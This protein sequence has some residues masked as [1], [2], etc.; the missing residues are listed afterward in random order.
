[1]PSPALTKALPLF[2]LP[3]RVRLFKSHL[4]PALLTY[5][6]RFQLPPKFEPPIGHY[7]GFMANQQC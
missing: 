2:I 6:I 5:L 3:L 7:S 1:M 4:K